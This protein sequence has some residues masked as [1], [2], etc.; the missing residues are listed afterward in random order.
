MSMFFISITAKQ[1]L[2]TSWSGIDVD[3]VSPM[4]EGTDSGGDLPSRS[5]EY[6]ALDTPP[7]APPI[8]SLEPLDRP[9]ELGGLYDAMARKGNKTNMDHW[10]GSLEVLHYDSVNISTGRQRKNGNST[11][12]RNFRGFFFQ[13]ILTEFVQLFEG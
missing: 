8:E 11:S 12:T 4:V 3:T 6:A 10:L 2:L 1:C 9:R 7:V 13:E 5:S